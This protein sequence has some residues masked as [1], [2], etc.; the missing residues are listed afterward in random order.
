M[1]S[2]PVGNPTD[3]PG[4]IFKRSRAFPRKINQAPDNGSWSKWSRTNRASVSKLFRMSTGRQ[5]HPHRGQARRVVGR[6]GG[7]VISVR[8]HAIDIVFDRLGDIA[9]GIEITSGLDPPGINALSGQPS[10]IVGGSGDQHRVGPAGDRGWP[11]VAGATV[12][13]NIHHPG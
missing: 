10:G 8:H 13:D 9:Q 6:L 7:L 12:G 1:R 11:G 3:N 2:I 4:P 5:H